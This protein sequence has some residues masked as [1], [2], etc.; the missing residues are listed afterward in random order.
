MNEIALSCL[1]QGDRCIIQS[2]GLYSGQR[3]RLR[4][5]GM[6][7]GTVITCAHIAPSGTPM[8]FWIKGA[9]IALRTEDCRRIRVTR[10]E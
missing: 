8:A 5:L 1:R 3:R 9:M 4:D 2:L 10:C 7:P 6:L